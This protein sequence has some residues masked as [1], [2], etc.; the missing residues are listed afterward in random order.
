MC[1][2]ELPI[3]AVVERRLT[4]DGWRVEVA[5]DGE[6][7]L[8]LAVAL[9]PDV[10]VTDLRM[11]RLTGVEFCRRLAEKLGDSAPPA[12]LLT[13]QGHTISDSD[14][15]GTRIARVMTKP[16]SPQRLERLLHELIAGGRSDAA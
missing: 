10:I 3:C 5:R 6:R 14:L 4:R 7:A 1:D 15:I 13:A 11:P 9:H 16:F 2:D 12:V 8:E